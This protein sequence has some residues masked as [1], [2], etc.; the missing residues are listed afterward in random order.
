MFRREGF[1]L[2]PP[3]SDARTMLVATS[4]ADGVKTLLLR[5]PGRRLAPRPLRGERATLVRGLP[6]RVSDDPRAGAPGVVSR[7]WNARLIE[8][9][10]LLPRS[11]PRSPHK[12]RPSRLA[13]LGDRLTRP[14]R[15]S[16]S[17]ARG[18]RVRKRPAARPEYRETCV[19]A[20]RG[21]YNVESGASKG[22]AS[23]AR[24]LSMG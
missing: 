1:R 24:A 15:R 8:C 6:W 18:F 13:S 5:G 4:R 12:D 16:D 3:A 19:P 9:L 14:G 20:G 7:S 2:V 23:R 22:S 11:R 21:L 10:R 17:T